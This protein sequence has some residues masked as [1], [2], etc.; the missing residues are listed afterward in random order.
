MRDAKDEQIY[1]NSY[2]LQPLS[3]DLGINKVFQKLI[4]LIQIL[5]CNMALELPV[6]TPTL[7]L[8]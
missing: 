8:C 6:I 2:N 7:W 1:Q 4:K 5:K 3:Y